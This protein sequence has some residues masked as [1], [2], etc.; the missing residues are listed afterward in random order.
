M[1]GQRLLLVLLGLAASACEPAPTSGEPADRNARVGGGA[2]A[3]GSPQAAPRLRT[4]DDT[5]ITM[6][7]PFTAPP[8]AKITG[9]VRVEDADALVL[10]FEYRAAQSPDEIIALYRRQAD[11]AGIVP[12]IDLSGRHRTL[13]GI[14]PVN[15]LEFIVTARPEGGG[16]AGQIMVSRLR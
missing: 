6:P 12:Q 11:A 8:D 7:A 10:H 13:G 2:A 1:I 4:G 14:D 15:G 9:V 16:S 5:P 3:A